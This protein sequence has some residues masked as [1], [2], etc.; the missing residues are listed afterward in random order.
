MRRSAKA[1]GRVKGVTTQALDLQIAVAGVR[2]V[3]E[4]G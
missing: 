3:A 2:G 1:S 4:R